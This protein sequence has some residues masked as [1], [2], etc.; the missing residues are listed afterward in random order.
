M[1]AKWSQQLSDIT[2]ALEVGHI[3]N[4]LQEIII[5]ERLDGS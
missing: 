1:G 3:K 4:H 2:A 5:T